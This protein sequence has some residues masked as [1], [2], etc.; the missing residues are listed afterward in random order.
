MNVFRR[1]SAPT[2]AARD[3]LELDYAFRSEAHGDDPVEVLRCGRHEDADRFSERCFYFGPMHELADVRG[4]DFF[5]TFGNEHE[6]HRQFFAGAANRMQ[7]GEK[8]RL[9]TFLIDGAAADDDFSEAGSVDEASLERRRSPFARIEL[10]DV[11]H[12]VQANGL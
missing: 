11:V 6:I 4:S 1:P 5:F 3:Q 10:L 12:E 8:R 2:L 7:G 9:G